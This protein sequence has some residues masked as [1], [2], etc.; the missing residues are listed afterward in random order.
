MNTLETV[1]IEPT[2]WC[3][4]KNILTEGELSGAL[5]LLGPGSS[6][7]EQT[8]AL[9]RV[10]FVAHGNVTAAI[11]TANFILKADQALHVAPDRPLVVRNHGESPAKVFILSV[12]APSRPKGNI[13]YLN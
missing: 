5:T 2:T 3:M 13:V 11:G 6:T 1:P 8:S 9:A 12:P 7:E 10:V 4:S